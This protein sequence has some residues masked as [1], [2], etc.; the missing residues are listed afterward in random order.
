[1]SCFCS[2][3]IIYQLIV[4]PKMTVGKAIQH[5]LLI[6]PIEIKAIADG[7]Q[8]QT[9]FR[10]GVEANVG[11]SNIF[12]GS[13]TE[14]IHCQP[15][16]IIRM[17]Q[18]GRFM[19]LKFFKSMDSIRENRFDMS[20]KAISSE[21]GSIIRPMGASSRKKTVRRLVLPFQENRVKVNEMNTLRFKEIF[22]CRVITHRRLKAAVF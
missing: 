9:I 12:N 16:I 20:Q 17:A 7:K 14:K 10:H 13:F 18:L 4:V 2:Y 6:Q 3:V 21:R 5:H 22:H 15:D 8:S 19:G 11:I 1:M